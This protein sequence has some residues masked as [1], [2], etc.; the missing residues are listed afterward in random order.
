MHAAVGTEE[1][2]DS[3]AGRR[4]GGWMPLRCRFDRS[5]SAQLPDAACSYTGP[6]ARR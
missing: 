4:M 3:V 2:S 1:Q 5:T 6:R